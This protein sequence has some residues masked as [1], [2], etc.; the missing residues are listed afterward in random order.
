MQKFYII[1][2]TGAWMMDE[3]AAFAESTKFTIFFIRKQDPFYDDKI[4]LL[5]EKGINIIYL[6]TRKSL[7]FYKLF[8]CFLFTIRHL[9]CFL[10]LHSFVY[11][12]KSLGY[13][14]K[15]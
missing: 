8:F 4:K 1:K 6:E 2:S 14:L 9:N 13:F 7:S 10:N 12:I 11:G 5:E 15:T 3:L